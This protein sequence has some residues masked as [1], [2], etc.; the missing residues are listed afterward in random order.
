MFVATILVVEDDELVADF[1]DSLLTDAGYTVLRESTAEAALKT[2]EGSSVDLVFTDVVMPG[3]MD[4]FKLAEMVG[5]KYPGVPV[6][7]A[8]GYPRQHETIHVAGPVCAA[9][10]RKPFRTADLLSTIERVR[11]E[12]ADR[13]NP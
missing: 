5:S 11:V 1:V 10:L 13:R 8:S 6:I 9:F 2:L 12:A 3:S 4:G 7:C